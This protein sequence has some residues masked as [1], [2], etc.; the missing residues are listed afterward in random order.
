MNIWDLHDYSCKT[1]V[2]TYEALEA[3]CTFDAASPF[4][5]CLSSFCQKNGKK[6][7]SSSVQ[8]LTVGERGVVRIWSSD[9]YVICSSKRFVIFINAISQHDMQVTACF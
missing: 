5:S 2:P 8:F 4:A 7:S 9:G 6:I 3:V 1:T